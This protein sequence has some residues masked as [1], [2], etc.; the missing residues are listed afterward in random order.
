MSE[1]SQHKSKRMEQLLLLF[2]AI[3]EKDKP[4]EAI[5]ENQETIDNTQASDIIALV[6][7]L[8]QTGIPIDK[9]KTGINK[10]INVLGK[11]IKSYPDAKCKKNSLLDVFMVNNA[12]L[13][14]KLKAVKPLFRQLNENPDDS[15]LKNEI[16]DHLA[17]IALF[18]NYY[19]IKENI[20]FPLIE[21]FWSDYRCLHMM[22]SFHDDIRSNL[23]KS[24]EMIQSETFD[25]MQ[26]N[27]LI[28]DLY[29]NMYAIVLREEKLLFPWVAETIPEEN[30]SSILPECIEMG[31]PYFQPKID[32]A[33]NASNNIVPEG[34]V[35]LETGALSADQIILLFN[36]LPVDI[37][38]V[39]ENNKVRYFSTPPKRIFPR[40]K[41]II[42]RDV[43]NCHPPESVHVVEQIVESF[44]NGEKNVAS[45]WINMKGDKILIQYFALRDKDGNYKGVIEVSQEI[46]SIQSLQGEQR[47]LDWAQ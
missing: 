1:I 23:K 36:H 30:L 11:T 42:G 27:K 7:I 33:M 18:E 29:F 41:A 10:F 47:L 4:V 21:K 34:T 32:A 40:S 16:A 17:A 38:F 39:D 26:F 43:H 25:L 31:F 13:S 5:R 37:T 14:E 6:D 44:R 20:L 2:H 8:M 22:W 3:L 46:G 28:G 9:L 35:N 24:L 12:I 45:F 19:A 15:Q